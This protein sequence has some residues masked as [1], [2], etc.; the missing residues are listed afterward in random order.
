MSLRGVYQGLTPRHK[1]AIRDRVLHWASLEEWGARWGM[2][3]KK[4]ERLWKR[5]AAQRYRQDIE[6]MLDQ[7]VIKTKMALPVLQMLTRLRRDGKI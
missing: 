6:D 7:E 5:P 4:A 2:E 1:K 3:R